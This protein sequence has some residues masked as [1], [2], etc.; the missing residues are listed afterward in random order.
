MRPVE[1]AFRMVELLGIHQPVGVSSLAT[2][3]DVPKTTAY[4]SL[5]ALEAIGWIEQVGDGTAWQLT[6]RAALAT[7]RPSP[8]EAMLRA[9]ALPVMEE[10]RRATEETI[11]LSA[12][13]ED[14]LILVERLDGIRPVRQFMA[15]GQVAPLHLT[16][17]GKA[18]LAAFPVPEADRIIDHFVTDLSER[19]T[20]AA[21]IA[22]ARSVGYA[23]TSDTFVHGT[24]AIGAAIRDSRGMPVCAVSVSMPRERTGAGKVETWGA[25][26]ANAAD[27][28]G[29]GLIS[30]R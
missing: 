9:A 28:I 19:E 20:L 8:V 4:R 30:V 12:V 26:V 29:M 15:R 22:T 3:A 7:T 2:M 5:K 1:L 13:F 16:A 17:S 25:M 11:H 24:T 23:T 14:R 6:L 18:V 21:E 10:L 27:R